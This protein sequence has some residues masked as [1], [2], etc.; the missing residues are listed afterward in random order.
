[1][2]IKYDFVEVNE[3]NKTKGKYRARAVSSGKITTDKL[4]QW[5][6]QTSGVSAAEAKG[7]IDILTDAMLD[8][9]KDGYEVQVGDLGYFSASVTSQLVDGPDEIRAESIRFNRLNYR[10]GIYVKKK[11]L[12]AGIERVERPRNKSKAK[13]TTRKE[14]AEMLK[15][16]L[17]EKP[18]ITRTDYMRLTRAKNALAAIRDL[19]AFIDEG[20]LTKYGAGRTV[21]YLLKQ[22]LRT[23]VIK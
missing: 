18:V 19:N 22:V 2:A 14:R 7:F 4:A 17:T 12:S 23:E 10:A 16:Y 13:E 8:F 5:I 15:E 21:V 1:M 6:R 3:L 20:W 11:I 9:I